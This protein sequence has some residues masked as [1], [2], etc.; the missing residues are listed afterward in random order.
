MTPCYKGFAFRISSARAR[1]SRHRLQLGGSRRV[2]VAAAA[3]IVLASALFVAVPGANASTSNS[4]KQA[5]LAIPSEE[6]VPTSIPQKMGLASLPPSG[7]R[8]VFLSQPAVQN[9]QVGQAFTD[10]AQAFGWTVSD[11]S[12]NEADPATL[13]AALTTALALHPLFVAMSGTEPTLISQSVRSAYIAA[14][15]P[16]DVDG[17]DP[18]TVTAPVIGCTDGGKVA[19][20]GGIWFANWFVAASHGKGKAIQESSPGYPILDTFNQGFAR[21]VAKI[22]PNCAVKTVPVTLQEIGSGSVTQV[23]TSTARSNLGY[24]YLVFNDGG[25]ADGIASDLAGAGLKGYTVGGYSLDTVGAQALKQGGD[26]AWVAVSTQWHGYALADAAAR[27]FTHSSGTALD[28]T[29]VPRQLL[30]KS[31][32]GTTVQWDE[33]ANALQLLK[34][35]WKVKAP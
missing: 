31:N 9:S 26:G 10:A 34:A 24:K 17:S 2:P 5:R 30:V 1:R 27:Y 13:D 20:L 15:V 21:Q 25:F 3:A 11:V 33:P 22:C 14:K 28:Q 12:Y 32:I 8:V 18:C 19:Y 29:T 16:I 4:V 35:L 6:K 23:M 7:K